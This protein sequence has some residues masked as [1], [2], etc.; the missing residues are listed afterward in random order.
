MVVLEAI[1]GFHGFMVRE[2][3]RVVQRW[4]WKGG[5]AV[6]VVFRFGEEEVRDGYRFCRW[7]IK[8]FLQKKKEDFVRWFSLLVNMGRREKTRFSFLFFFVARREKTYLSF[9]FASW[10]FV[11]FSSTF[12]LVF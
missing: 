12:F 8:D 3:K 5:A 6:V 1:G 7:R 10:G 11:G 4:K 9:H 2:K